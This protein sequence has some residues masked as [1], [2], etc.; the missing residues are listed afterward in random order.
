M[1]GESFGFLSGEASRE[2]RRRFEGEK[3]TTA[4][5]LGSGVDGDGEDGEGSDG[6]GGDL[7]LGAKKR[8]ITCCFCLPISDSGGGTMV[9]RAFSRPK[10]RFSRWEDGGTGIAG[11]LLEEKCLMS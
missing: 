7:A 6:R 1:C 8:D 3:E 10:W 5:I 4:A 2:E 11:L 9:S